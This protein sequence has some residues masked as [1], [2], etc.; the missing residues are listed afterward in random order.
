MSNKKTFLIILVFI[1]STA[2]IA[3]ESDIESLLEDYPEAREEILENYR[4]VAKAKTVSGFHPAKDI[5]SFENF[6][7]DQR[8]R[9]TVSYTQLRKDEDSRSWILGKTDWAHCFAMSFLTKQFFE[10]ARFSES[11]PDVDSNELVRK[12]RRVS[13]KKNENFRGIDLWDL[14]S[15]HRRELVEVLVPLQRELFF[16][17][18]SIG[19]LFGHDQK[20]AARKIK[21]SI[22]NDHLALTGIKKSLS[23]QHVV[24]SYKYQETDSYIRFYIY[25]SN[26][27]V[28]STYDNCYITYDK[29]SERFVS[30]HYG[31]FTG[32]FINR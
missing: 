11:I 23:W 30:S 2:V 12:I 16:S 27:P 24:L 15:N 5:I 10:H 14:S 7:M 4:S 9:E 28:G 21:K 17:P 8:S 19:L 25:D 31:S 29:V 6:M 26:Y 13:D 20:K 22:Q 3:V 32:F 18:S 1:L